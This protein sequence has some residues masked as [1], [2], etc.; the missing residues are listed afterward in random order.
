MA[1]GKIMQVL[2]II[3]IVAMV[4]CVAC[5][6]VF[7]I[8]HTVYADDTQKITMF[9]ADQLSRNTQDFLFQNGNKCVGLQYLPDGYTVDPNFGRWIVSVV[10]NPVYTYMGGNHFNPIIECEAK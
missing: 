9:Q 5:A 2:V 7:M 10:D 8:V 4:A 1:R 3:A 6:S